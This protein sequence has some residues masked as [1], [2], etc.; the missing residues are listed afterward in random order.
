[1]KLSGLEGNFRRYKGLLPTET[2]LKGFNIFIV[3]MTIRKN[4]KLQLCR[5]QFLMEYQSTNQQNIVT[6]KEDAVGTAVILDFFVCSCAL[7][8][9]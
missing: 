6:P 9:V 1:M 8:A 7:T 3:M 5:Q 2:T 4:L